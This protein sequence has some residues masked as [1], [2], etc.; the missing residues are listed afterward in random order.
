[1]NE[2]EAFDRMVE[3]EN[4]LAQ[5]EARPTRVDNVK[6]WCQVAF[7]LTVAVFVLVVMWAII[8]AMV[9]GTWKALG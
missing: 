3:A 8:L 9:V 7:V 4:K 5:A 1:M 2:Q 6:E